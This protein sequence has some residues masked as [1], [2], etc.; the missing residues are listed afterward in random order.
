MEE[1]KF[2]EELQFWLNKRKATESMRDDIRLRPLARSLGF[3]VIYGNNFG[4]SLM[5]R[6][7][8]KH[9]WYCSQGWACVTSPNVTG[10]TPTYYPS[11]QDALLSVVEQFPDVSPCDAYQP[12]V[13]EI[14]TDCPGTDECDS[15]EYI[16]IVRELQPAE[17][18]RQQKAKSPEEVRYLIDEIRNLNEPVVYEL[19]FR[20]R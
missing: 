4:D 7:N 12:Y 3:D 16:F 2:D 6:G 10:E 13:V 20:R 17:K 11:L 19:D 14:I 1:S 15:R 5:F 9:V 18:E 8:G